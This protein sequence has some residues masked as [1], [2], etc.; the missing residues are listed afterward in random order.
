MYYTQQAHFFHLARCSNVNA[1]KLQIEY[2]ESRT[3]EVEGGREKYDLITENRN[4]FVM[5]MPQGI[6]AEI[7]VLVTVSKKVKLKN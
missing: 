2:R 5:R 4:F 6:T 1:F 7:S 3:V